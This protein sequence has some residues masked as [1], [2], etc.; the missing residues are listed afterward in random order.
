MRARHELLQN[1][2]GTYPEEDYSYWL[3]KTLAWALPL[4]VWIA[5]IL[6]LGFVFIYMMKAHPWIRLL[7]D[8]KEEEATEEE[9]E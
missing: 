1:T 4:T 3:V 7:T 9:R 5:G 2:I 6:D 8:E